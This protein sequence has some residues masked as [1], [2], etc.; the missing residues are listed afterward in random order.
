MSVASTP[1]RT[2]EPYGI[3]RSRSL[4][5]ATVPAVAKADIPDSA[6]APDAAT[7]ARNSRLV[8]ALTVMSASGSQFDGSGLASRSPT[9]RRWGDLE[10]RWLTAARINHRRALPLR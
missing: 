1:A 8:W 9:A 6:V 5:N 3:S 10:A 2:A 4:A 7:L